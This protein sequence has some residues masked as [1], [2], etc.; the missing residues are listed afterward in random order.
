MT[1]EDK[2]KTAKAKINSAEALLHEAADTSNDEIHIALK[3]QYGS[4]IKPSQIA[5]LRRK[6]GIV[7][8]KHRASVTT[9]GKQAA[10]AIAKPEKRKYTKRTKLTDEQIKLM[11]GAAKRLQPNVAK[12]A[13][14]IRKLLAIHHIEYITVYRDK[15]VVRFARYEESEATV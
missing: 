3:K 12:V 14:R 7:K 4:S 9:F 5:E 10:K 6:L 8:T 1:K 2:S 13:A 11:T 15:P